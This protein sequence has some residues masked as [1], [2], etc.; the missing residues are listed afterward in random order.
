MVM[1]RLRDVARRRAVTAADVIVLIVLFVVGVLIILMLLPRGR[2]HS[3]MAACEN[4]LA[5]IGFAVAVFDGIEN[6]LP[7]VEGVAA[8]DSPRE[9]RPK[10]VLRTMIETLQQPDFLGL[11][12]A[13]M[14]PEPRPGDVPGEMP[15]RGLMCASDPNAT[16]GVFVAPSSYRACTGDLP[17]GENGAFAPGRKIS[18]KEVQD[19]DGTSYTGMFSERLVGDNRA[20]HAV[21]VNY[22]IANGPLGDAGCAAASEPSR[23]RGDAGSSWVSSDYRS[24]L[25]NHAL[26]PNEQPSC[27][28]G[29]GRAA[30]M[31]ASSGH[32]AG[33]NL[34]FADGHVTVLSAKVDAKIWRAFA[35][36]G[37]DE[38][39]GSIHAS[40]RLDLRLR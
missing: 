37:D 20:G 34:L 4:N 31:G 5:H 32:I 11:A 10:S 33:V 35:R 24:T 17:A 25:Y 21:A 28:E 26:R 22:M 6:R 3:R 29:G 13:K 1:R 14:R 18:L 30:F 12:D 23:W 16:S 19:Q 40:T 36:I 8:V 7:L 9:G 15:V 39:D 27:I 2:E 38:A